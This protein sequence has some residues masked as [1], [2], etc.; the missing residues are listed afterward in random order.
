MCPERGILASL[1]RLHGA[2]SARPKFA[3]FARN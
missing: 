1:S 2:A 3:V